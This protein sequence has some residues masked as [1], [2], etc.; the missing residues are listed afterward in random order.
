MIRKL[1]EIFFVNIITTP[2]FE[3][4]QDRIL[5]VKVVYV[6]AIQVVMHCQIVTEGAVA[7]WDQVNSHVVPIFF[8]FE[9]IS[10]ENVCF[11]VDIN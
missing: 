6:M 2:I 4:V 1:F 3:L 11:R 9:F 5:I 7:L 10:A 8:N